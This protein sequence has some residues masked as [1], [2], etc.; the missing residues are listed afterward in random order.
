MTTRVT[1]SGQY[2]L[3]RTTND[4]RILALD[5]DYFALTTG[6]KGEMLVG[7]DPD[8]EKKETIQKGSYKLVEFED[9]PKFQDIPHLFLEKDGKYDEVVVPRGIPSGTGDQQRF[10]YTDHH[11][12]MNEVEDYVRS[13]AEGDGSERRGRPGGGAVANV[14]HYLKGVDY[15][16]HKN[17]LQEHARKKDA[18]NDVMDQLGKL[19]SKRF[20]SMA[21]VTRHLGQK[22]QEGRPPIDNYDQKDVRDIQAAMEDLDRP[23]LRKVREYEEANY[24]RQTI[25]EKSAQLLEREDAPVKDYPNLSADELEDRIPKLDR[26]ELQQL[27]DYEESHENR[28]TV[29]QA[30]DRQLDSS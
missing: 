20:R 27:R 6:Q 12:D 8:H 14:T 5:N 17:D 26:K 19:E 3:F 7:S 4:N 18:P 2:E 29:L 13:P 10:I 28:K 22:V 23:G 24:G 30:I 21:D 9:D 25:L 16:A 1:R 15:P 11:L